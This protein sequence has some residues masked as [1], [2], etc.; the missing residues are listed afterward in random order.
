MLALKVPC[1]QRVLN[2]CLLPRTW[3]REGGGR[4]RGVVAAG[5]LRGAGRHLWP[6]RSLG[7]ALSMKQ[8]K[9]RK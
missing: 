2:K 9:K 6:S 4:L 1:I 7:Q 3:S 5:K 8:R